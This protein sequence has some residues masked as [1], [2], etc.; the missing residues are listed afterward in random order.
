MNVK[1]NKENTTVTII[2]EGK[3]DHITVSDFE[4][5]VHENAPDAEFM[6]MDFNNLEYISSAGLRI[7]LDA[8]DLM[9]EKNG[10]KIINVNTQIC[11]IFEMTGFADSLNIEK[12]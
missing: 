7:I 10:L 9:A 4:K 3:I 12:K 2:P 8:D 5:A 11:S 6:V 1:I